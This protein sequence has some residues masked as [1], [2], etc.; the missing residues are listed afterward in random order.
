MMSM[1]KWN[2]LQPREF[3]AW[4]RFLIGWFNDAQIGCIDPTLHSSF[5]TTK[6]IS[7][8]E[9]QDQGLKAL[10]VKLSNTK[11]LV[12]EVRRNEGFDSIPQSAEGVLVYRVDVTKLSNQGMA[13]IITDNPT[14][15]E[16][17]MIGT[18]HPGSSITDSGV[19]VKVIDSG[20]AGDTV[21]IQIN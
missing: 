16:G 9:R 7:P 11:A 20:A 3:L 4:T 18:M 12:V 5:S 10:I 6:L 14:L 21:N 17:M 15:S 2:V 19:T 1:Q 8:L 13:T